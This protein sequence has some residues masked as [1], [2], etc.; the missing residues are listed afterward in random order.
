MSVSGIKPHSLVYCRATLHIVF[1]S[2]ILLHMHARRASC[3]YILF[4]ISI[5]MTTVEATIPAVMQM[6]R[7]CGMGSWTWSSFGAWEQM[8]E[9]R[10]TRQGKIIR[11]KLTTT[12]T[13]NPAN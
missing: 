7:F 9:L 12:D 10:L 8:S 3:Y 1:G 2:S 4:G 13:E 11:G 5:A 6:N